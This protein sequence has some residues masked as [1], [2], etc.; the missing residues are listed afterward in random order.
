M[1]RDRNGRI[2]GNVTS[3]LLRAF[4]HDEA[5]E[6]TEIYIVVLRQGTLDA[7]HKSLD[8]SLD[9]Y[10][11]STG[12]FSDFANDICLCLTLYIYKLNSISGL[13]I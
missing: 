11:F 4:F 7:L 2:L 1:G 12:T 3:H 10:F 6:T 8:D 13:Q 9:L 5:A